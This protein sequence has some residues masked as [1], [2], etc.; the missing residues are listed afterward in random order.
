MSNSR[1]RDSNSSF[2]GNFASTPP[3]GYLFQ[4][5][6]YQSISEAF[7]FCTLTLQTDFS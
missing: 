7:C 4:L 6:V 2:M 3:D 5:F 1:F